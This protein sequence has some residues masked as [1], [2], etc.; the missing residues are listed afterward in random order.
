MFSHRRS[1]RQRVGDPKRNEVSGY[2]KLHIH[3]T[4]S[5]WCGAEAWRGG[6][7]VQV[8]SSSSDRVSKLRSLSQNIPSVASKRDVN[9]IKAKQKTPM[10]GITRF[11]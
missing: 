4:S 9:E 7:R 2:R 11:P 6:V 10:S 1:W 3:Q 8:S 5:R